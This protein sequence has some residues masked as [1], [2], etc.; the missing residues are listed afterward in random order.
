MGENKWHAE[1]DWPLP[2]TE[3]TNYYGLYPCSGGRGDG[4]G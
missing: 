4:E 2:G 3:W 1:A